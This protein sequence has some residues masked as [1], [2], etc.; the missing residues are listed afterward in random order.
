MEN[1][2]SASHSHTSDITS[3]A[4]SSSHTGSEHSPTHEANHT[5]THEG[6]VHVTAVPQNKAQKPSAK[7]VLGGKFVGIGGHLLYRKGH[8]TRGLAGA[9]AP[10]LFAKKNITLEVVKI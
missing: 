2:K 9:L 5:K 8:G 7:Q 10:D 3:S 4:A 1:D 6:K